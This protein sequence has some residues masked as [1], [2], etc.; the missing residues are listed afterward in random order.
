V[1]VATC[2]LSLAISPA[3]TLARSVNCSG[4]RESEGVL[5][6]EGP[7]EVRSPDGA[8]EVAVGRKTFWGPNV[9]TPTPIVIRRCDTSRAWPAFKTGRNVGVWWGPHDSLAMVDFKDVEDADV[10]L[11]TLDRVTGA[12]QP[13]PALNA[14]LHNDVRR[15]IGPALEVLYLTPIVAAWRGRT[16]V[17]AVGGT[18]AARNRDGPASEFCFGYVVDTQ[19]GQI[20]RALKAE[21]LRR[22]YN[23]QCETFH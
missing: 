18:M 8:W 2:V 5:H 13:A 4:P 3:S 16:T 20:E 7:G 9:D 19:T 15:R 22:R 23:T 11:F 12:R 6:W 21:T 1:L 17:L 10:Y 14:S